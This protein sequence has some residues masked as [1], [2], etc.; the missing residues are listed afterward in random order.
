VHAILIGGIIAAAV[1]SDLVLARPFG[2]PA[3]AQAAALAAGPCLYLLG[4]AAYK[5]VVY[6]V[7][8][9]SHILAAAALVLLAPLAGRVDLLTLAALDTVLLLAV[10][11]RERRLGRMP[12]PLAAPDRLQR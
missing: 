2:T 9:L 8:P 6:G 3:P 4:S 5:R 11:Y 10:A 7:V 12:A 1:G